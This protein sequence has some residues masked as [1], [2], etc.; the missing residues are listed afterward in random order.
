MPTT[1]PILPTARPIIGRF[2]PSPTGA[3]HLGSLTTALASF[4]HIKSLGGKWLVRIE[5]TDFERCKPAFSQQILKDLQ[6]LGLHWDDEILYQSQRMDIYH[7]YLDKLDKLIYPCH[8]SR[9]KL[10]SYH[11]PTYPRLCTPKPPYHFPSH[12]TDSPQDHFNHTH[13]PSQDRIR[14]Q[15][16]DCAYGFVDGLQGIQW[17]NPQQLL[18][19]VVIKRN[20]GMINYLLA[21]A[22]DDGLSNISHTMRG[23]DILPMTATQLFI[24]KTLGLP[25]SDYFYH[26]PL[27]INADGQKLSKQNLAK[28]IDVSRPSRLLIT[29][30]TL[31]KQ[32]IPDE[33]HRA[34]PQEILAY[35]ICHWDNTPLKN[36]TAFDE[37]LCV[38]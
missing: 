11:Q 25:H 34:T 10:E 21:C 28:P 27:I 15:L 19:D 33:L 18:G 37:G 9:K 6:I 1:V 30:L 7:H 22:I 17:Q 31:L 23:L 35:A 24:A 14:L 29:A 26:L 2:A 8:C 16:P 5:D 12:Q 13:Y 38:Y 4:C 20:N 3:L 36:Q 32:P